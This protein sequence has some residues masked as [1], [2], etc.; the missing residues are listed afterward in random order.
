MPPFSTAQIYNFK[1]D[2]AIYSEQ[3]PI[4]YGDQGGQPFRRSSGS[5]GSDRVKGLKSS[6]RPDNWRWNHDLAI[7]QRFCCTPRSAIPAHA[8]SGTIRFKKGGAS[9]LRIS[10]NHGRLRC[11]ATRISQWAGFAYTLGCAGRQG[12]KRQPDEHHLSFQPIAEHHRVESTSSRWAG[13]S[14]RSQTTSNP[15]DLAELNGRYHV[16]PRANRFA[17]QSHRHG[18]RFRQF[19]PRPAQILPIAERIAGDRRQH[20]LRLSCSLL[21]GQLEGHLPAHVEPRPSLRWPRPVRPSWEPGRSIR[22]AGRRRRPWRPSPA[23]SSSARSATRPPL[24][25]SSPP[26]GIAATA[27]PR[28]AFVSSS[29]A[30]IAGRRGRTLAMSAPLTRNRA[31]TATRARRASRSSRVDTASKGTRA[32]R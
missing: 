3:S 2:H 1:F 26:S 20:S 18:S 12:R 9:R 24:Q 11:N 5:S 25:R 29:W 23:G 21:S 32:T 10:G 30:L 7:S 4:I 19:V 16:C 17:N 22:A 15:L 8:N 6:Q 13:T 31:L 28:A 27:V 14:G